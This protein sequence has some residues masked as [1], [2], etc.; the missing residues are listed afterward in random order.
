MVQRHQTIGQSGPVQSFR[1]VLCGCVYRA[2][3]WVQIPLGLWTELNTCLTQADPEQLILLA[4]HYHQYWVGHGQLRGKGSGSTM[5]CWRAL[6]GLGSD[7]T[8]GPASA[9]WLCEVGWL[10][11]YLFIHKVET[12]VPLVLEKTREF[13]LLGDRNSRHPRLLSPDWTKDSWLSLKAGQ[14]AVTSPKQEHS[15]KAISY[16]PRA[17]FPCRGSSLTYCPWTIFL[18]TALQQ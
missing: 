4:A 10:H 1:L 7:W 6:T 16:S 13:A 5:A 14:E 11:I 18:H 2:E 9:L 15:T 8:S 12:S 17:R 3:L